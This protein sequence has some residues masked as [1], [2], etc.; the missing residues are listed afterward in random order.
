MLREERRGPFPAQR[1]SGRTAAFAMTMTT[2]LQQRR[3]PLLGIINPGQK[4]PTFAI[5]CK[6]SLQYPGDANPSDGGR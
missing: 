2:A 6:F 1:V 3:M 4:P 5:N